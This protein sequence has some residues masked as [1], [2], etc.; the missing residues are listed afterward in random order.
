MEEL[1][2]LNNLFAL[3]DD[4]MRASMLILLVIF[5]FVIFVMLTDSI[6]KRGPRIDD[7][8]QDS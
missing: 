8:D 6:P 7:D 1:N 2:D 4:P 3:L 5:A